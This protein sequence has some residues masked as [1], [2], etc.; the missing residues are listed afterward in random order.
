MHEE[1]KEEN[2]VEKETSQIQTELSQKNLFE[3][4]LDQ[5]KKSNKS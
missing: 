2:K 3:N 1:N 5:S 4:F